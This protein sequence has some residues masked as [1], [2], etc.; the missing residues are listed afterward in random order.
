[1]HTVTLM[2]K[3]T[4]AETG[5]TYLLHIINEMGHCGSEGFKPT[6]RLLCDAFMKVYSALIHLEKLQKHP[7]GQ[8]LHCS[9]VFSAGSLFP[10]GVLVVAGLIIHEQ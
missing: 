2:Q 5:Q 6:Q 9:T 4:F 3:L 7:I 1:M 10:R 8:N